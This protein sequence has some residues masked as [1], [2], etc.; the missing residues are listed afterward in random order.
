MILR[1]EKFLDEKRCGT[2][3]SHGAVAI[4]SKNLNG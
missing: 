2:Q 3:L 4:T 1:S